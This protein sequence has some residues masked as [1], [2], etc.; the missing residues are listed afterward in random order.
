MKPTDHEAGDTI[1]AL[2]TP[3]GVSG[4]GVIRLSG[5]DAISILRRVFQ[6]SGR[7]VDF[8]D[9]RAVYGRLRDPEEDRVLDDGMALVMRGPTTYTGDDV[10]ELSLH[11]SPLVLDLVVRAIVR[12]GARPAGKGEFT[13]R[14]FLSGKLDL[15]QA[16][17]VI[18]LIEAASPSAVEEARAR[19][20]KSVSDEILVI[21]E[22]LKDLLAELEAHIDFDEDEEEPA[23]NPEPSLHGILDKMRA[24]R[25]GAE[26][27][28]IRRDGLLTVIVGKPNV[29]KST[30]FNALIRADRVIVTPFPGTTRDTV[31]EHLLLGRVHLRVCDTAG[32]R[33]HPDPVEEE[34]V[35]R[36]LEKIREADLVIAVVDGSSPLDDVDDKVVMTCKEKDI[37]VALNKIDLG[38]AV[39]PNAAPLQSFNGTYVPISAKTGA[40]LAPL[41]Q[42]MEE[43]ACSKV[44]VSPGGAAGLSQRGLLLLEAAAVPIESLLSDIDRG[45][46][47]RPE[48]VS[49]E[50]RRALAH[51]EEITGER[52]DE[53]VLERIF[54]RFC[55]GK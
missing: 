11:G 50:V 32:I 3:R 16:E 8:P 13:R 46:I 38:L 25:V 4:I 21:A 41:R 34:G 27:G 18:D 51:L 36:T 26:R 14:A 53:G 5:P 42:L 47:V 30:L 6:P 43:I 28:R 49:L 10:V 37:V 55:V 44:A 7:R 35:R 48:I 52:V 45:E 2:S 17:A 33:E 23:P 29:G 24:L 20:D 9:R 1:V 39:D 31:E 15:V 19:L 22:E 12:C 40:G 54:E